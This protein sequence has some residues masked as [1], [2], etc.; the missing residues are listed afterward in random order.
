MSVWRRPRAHP[1]AASGAFARQRW[2]N[3]GVCDGT[4][5]Q[6]LPADEAALLL[7]VVQLPPAAALRRATP[8]AEGH[9]HFRAIHALVGTS[10]GR[11]KDVK[12]F[13]CSDDCARCGTAKIDRMAKSCTD[14][15]PR[16]CA[17][18][19]PIVRP[20]SRNCW[21]ITSRRRG[22]PK[23]RSNG[24]AKPAIRR[25]ADPPFRRPFPISARPSRWRIKGPT[26]LPPGDRLRLQ[27]A[28][29]NALVGLRG[30]HSS[31]TTAAFSRAR[32]LAAAS[33]EP[34]ERFSVYWGLWAGSFARCETTVCQELS[35][36]MLKDVEQWPSSPESCVAHRLYGSTQ[37]VLGNYLGARDHLEQAVAR[38][39]PERDRELAFRFGLDIGVCPRAYLPL[40]LWPLGEVDRARAAAEDTVALATRTEHAPTLA[41]AHFWI[42]W[43]EM[44]RGDPIR[45]KP[46]A[47]ATMA[48]ARKHDMNFWRLVAPMA[49]GWAIAA[50][51]GTEAG[52][53]EVRRGVAGC[54]E[55]GI[56]A[57]T[58]SYDVQLAAMKARAGYLDAALAMLGGALAEAAQTKAR[59]YVVDGHRIRGE[60]LLK[61]DPAHTAPAE[62]A[63]LAA[64][65]I[66]QQQ[67]VRSFELRAALALAK[68]HQSTNRAADAHAVLAPALQGFSP[69]PEFSEIEEAQALVA[70]L[71]L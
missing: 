45:S 30:Q 59:A 29:S 54:R 46:H 4:P 6:V 64:I 11:R 13:G 21:R 2:A 28:Y 57:F 5:A 71:A 68:L 3:Y 35:T 51:D 38:H 52:W 44:V 22:S 20:P 24:G 36:Q 17:T 16:Y 26:L 19:L 66:A 34:L 50:A 18:N 31:E 40:A 8:S 25:C 9:P 27:T 42:A 37:W 1:L 43:Y 58:T 62:E 41:Y 65:A 61:R 15:S 70:T 23:P 63:F 39:N 48:L 7:L 49:H 69:T 32:E 47:E 12:V 53:D 56:T 10:V 55:Q 14:A 33:Q 67:K 60:I